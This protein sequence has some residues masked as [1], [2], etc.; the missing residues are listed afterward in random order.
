M[1]NPHIT[2]I[3]QGKPPLD[4]WICKYC[5]QQGTYDEIENIECSYIYPPCE[6]CGQ[7]PICAFN[8][9]GILN[10]L[11]NSNIYIAGFEA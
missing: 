10:A 11:A 4:W 6:H 7:T 3:R 9:E 8:C 5:H 2:L 1:K